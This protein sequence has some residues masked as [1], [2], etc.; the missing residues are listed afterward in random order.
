MATELVTTSAV[1]RGDVFPAVAEVQFRVVSGGRSDTVASPPF[2][3]RF[4]SPTK[5]KHTTGHETKAD[6]LQ[7]WE[8]KKCTLMQMITLC[9][10]QFQRVPLPSHRIFI[11]PFSVP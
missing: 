9:N 4:R 7:R 1:M 10:V 2:T 6:H 3:F 8:G 5:T 11:E